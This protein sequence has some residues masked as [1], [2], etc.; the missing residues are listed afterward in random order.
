MLP[1]RIRLLPPELDERRL[2]HVLRVRR[3][4]HPLPRK[5]QQLGRKLLVT[6]FPGIGRGAFI[7]AARVFC[8]GNVAEHR[9][10]LGKCPYFRQ[11][12]SI[13]VTRPSD[14]LT[15]TERL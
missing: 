2:H 10:C 15:A 14:W 5:E 4:R 6:R 11:P 7:H 3:L 13:L 1:T 9:S 8:W 12:Q